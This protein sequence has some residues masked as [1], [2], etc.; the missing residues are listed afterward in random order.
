MLVR[1]LMLRN[2][3][4]SL[5]LREVEMVNRERAGKV[6]LSLCV[7]EACDKMRQM[8]LKYLLEDVTDSIC[9]EMVLN[10]IIA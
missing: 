5:K 4:K 3:Y 10:G 6:F 1:K 8:T 7:V 9:Y 2:N